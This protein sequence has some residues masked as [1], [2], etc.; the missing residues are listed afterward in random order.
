MRSASCNL[1]HLVFI[2]ISLSMLFPSS[3][4]A[5]LW[6]KKRSI[7]LCQLWANNELIR[8]H[9]PKTRKMNWYFV[10][11][12][13]WNCFESGNFLQRILWTWAGE[14]LS[15]S[16]LM[17]AVGKESSGAECGLVWRYTLYT[18]S[19]RIP[20]VH[21]LVHVPVCP[22]LELT[23]RSSILY[24]NRWLYILLHRNCSWQ[25]H[26]TGKAQTF[27]ARGICIYFK[28]L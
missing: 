19:V 1:V 5:N 3:V 13:C 21:L 10:K 2:L 24:I 4:S 26:S 15:T 28:F 9:L 11:C 6:G 17:P 7:K 23:T 25:H 20:P 12:H 14:A 27:G 18:V 8:M 22:S 16:G